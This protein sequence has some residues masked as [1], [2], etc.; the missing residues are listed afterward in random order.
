MFQEQ[1]PLAAE[2]AAAVAALR[3]SPRVTPSHKSAHVGWRGSGS[4]ARASRHSTPR[5]L[6]RKCSCPGTLRAA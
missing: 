5:D 1:K 6:A 2:S 4:L 3:T